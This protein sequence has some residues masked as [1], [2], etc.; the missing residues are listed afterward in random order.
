MLGHRSWIVSALAG[1][2][3]FRAGVRLTPPKRHAL[4]DLLGRPRALERQIDSW[5]S[6]AYGLLCSVNERSMFYLALPGLTLTTGFPE[7][8]C[9]YRMTLGFRPPPD[10][11]S[12]GTTV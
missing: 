11:G 5:C 12:G 3:N 1:R 7:L 6:P 2:S 9:L 4:A 10:Y 8:C